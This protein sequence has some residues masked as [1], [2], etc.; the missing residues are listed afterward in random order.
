MLYLVKNNNNKTP[1]KSEFMLSTLVNKSAVCVWC[2]CVFPNTKARI[3]STFQ[4]RNIGP[5]RRWRKWEPTEDGEILSIPKLRSLQ[6]LYHLQCDWNCVTTVA[7]RQRSPLPSWP[8]T[9]CVP[10]V[11]YHIRSLNNT[12][13]QF[14]EL[15]ESG[16]LTSPALWTCAYLLKWLY[17]Q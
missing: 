7:Q 9:G 11:T 14:L 16:V 8:L 2:V 10:L 5:E 1:L 12:V 4:L 3:W 17:L 15:D 13:S 6:F